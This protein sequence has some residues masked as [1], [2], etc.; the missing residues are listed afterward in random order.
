[1]HCSHDDRRCALKIEAANIYKLMRQVRATPQRIPPTNS[2]INHHRNTEGPLPSSSSTYSSSYPPSLFEELMFISIKSCPAPT[3]H[4][5]LWSPGREKRGENQKKCWL[6][7]DTASLMT[8]CRRLASVRG[9]RQRGQDLIWVGQ[10]VLANR[11]MAL[12]CGEVS[13]TQTPRRGK[14]V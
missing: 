9:R 6:D 14:Q 8:S 5:L 12:L 10:G 2:L 4:S 1:M 3:A 13:V 11:K 7:T